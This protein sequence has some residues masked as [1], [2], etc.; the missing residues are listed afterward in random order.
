MRSEKETKSLNLLG[1]VAPVVIG[2]LLFV[3]FFISLSH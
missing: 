3:S 1:I 2:L